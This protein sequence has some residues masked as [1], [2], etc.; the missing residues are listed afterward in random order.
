MVSVLFF[1]FVFVKSWSENIIGH[2][3][4]FFLAVEIRT[5]Y[6]ILVVFNVRQEEL[7]S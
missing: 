1:V 6:F 4:S 2:R 5:K 7:A 3:V